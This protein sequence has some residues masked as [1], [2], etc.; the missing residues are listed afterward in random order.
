VLD[1]RLGG[2]RET[3]RPRLEWEEHVE[4]LACKRERESYQR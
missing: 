1:A 2:G 4:K 3:G